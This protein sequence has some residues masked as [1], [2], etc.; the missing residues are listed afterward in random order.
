MASLKVDQSLGKFA[1][2]VD[3]GVG[4]RAEEFSYNDNGFWL[5]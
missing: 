3:L 2:T 1:A 5:I 4:K